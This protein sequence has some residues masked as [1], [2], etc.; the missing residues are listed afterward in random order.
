MLFYLWGCPRILLPVNGDF[1]MGLTPKHS[2]E[3]LDLA[4]PSSAGWLFWHPS[5]GKEVP[6]WAW[7]LKQLM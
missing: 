7:L 3:F 6:G 5:G 1:L 4:V 2:V